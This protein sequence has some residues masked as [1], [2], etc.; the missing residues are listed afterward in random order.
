MKLILV[1][2]FWDSFKVFKKVLGVCV[3][4]SDAV[5]IVQYIFIL[6]ICGLQLRFTL[7]WANDSLTSASNIW[8]IK[9]KKDF[10][11]YSQSLQLA[12]F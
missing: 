5:N 8:P 2:P 12:C 10:L 11:G 3:L 1:K 6:Y 4:K 9:K 7:G